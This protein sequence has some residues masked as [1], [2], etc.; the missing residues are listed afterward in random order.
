M[1]LLMSIVL[2]TLTFASDPFTKIVDDVNSKTVKLFGSGGFRG[3]NN[4]GTGIVVSEDGHILTVANQ[5]V[6]TSEIIV[7]LYDGRRMKATLVAMEAE[8][9]VALLKIR[10]EGKKPEEPTGLN[11]PFYDIPSA[12]K[13]P[14]AQPGDWVLSFANQFEIA[15][16]DEPVSVQRGVVAAYAKLAGR[17]GI[18]DFPFTG[19]VYVVDAIMNNPGAA[20]GALTNRKGELLGLVGRELKN[21]LSETWMN[22]AIP[23][24]AKAELREGDKV[25]TI[26][27]PEFVEKAMKGQY[28]T[29]PRQQITTGPGGYHGIVFVPNVLER[30][31]PY[32]EELEAN[33]PAAKA[34]IKP[35]DLVSFLDGEPI[36][37]IKAFQ[38]AIKKTRPGSVVKVEVR[39]GDQLQSFDLKL[40]EFPKPVAKKP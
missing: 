1:T 19:Q 6:D 36:G 20:G 3:V 38:E 16:R 32:V 35:N 25:T 13:K 18:F 17:K 5:L 8:L 15:M 34:G 22:Y 23:I 26:T 31:P 2:A 28:K 29:R 40:E 11:L 7:H 12:A 14:L 30:T 27:I 24:Q 4:F 39:R 33:S 9:D 10:I 37:N 21:A